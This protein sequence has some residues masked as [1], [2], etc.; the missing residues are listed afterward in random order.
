MQRQP[1]GV[2]TR[3]EREV[4]EAN[5]AFY[6][7]FRER[8]SARMDSL[9]AEEQPVAVIHPGWQVLYGRKAVLESWHGILGGTEPPEIHCGEAQVYSLGDTAFVICLEHL[10][11]GDLIATNIFTREAGRW[12][13]VHHQAGPTPPAPRPDPKGSVH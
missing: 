11:G 7:A 3:D 1:E 4:L 6:Q 8:D 2:V 9:W 12:R 10:P 5:K 13:L